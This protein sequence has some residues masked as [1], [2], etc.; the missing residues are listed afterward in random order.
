MTIAPHFYWLENVLILS[1]LP[2]CGKAEHSWLPRSFPYWVRL[3]WTLPTRWEVHTHFLGHEL[4]QERQRLTE[5]RGT[6]SIPTWANRS[7]LALVRFQKGSCCWHVLSQR[8]FFTGQLWCPGLRV[9]PHSGQ[10]VWG[11]R[12]SQSPQIFSSA[13]SRITLYGLPSSQGNSN[14]SLF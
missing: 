13:Y 7:D 12:I 11:R 1:F 6:Y 8:L 14:S 9:Q 4:H 10:G 5:V 2:V 3:S